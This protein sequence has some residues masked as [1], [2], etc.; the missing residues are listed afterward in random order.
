MGVGQG[1]LNITGGS[2]M[3]HLFTFLL[4]AVMV[5]AMVTGASAQIATHVVISEVY[6]GGG[7]SGA[8]YTHDFVELYNPTAS[9]VTMTNWSLQYQSATGSG[10][11]SLINVF[12]G[13]I[14]AH[15]FFLVQLAQGAG[16]S[17]SLPTPDATPASPLALAA[18]A[19]KVALVS[20]GT[21]IEF[22]TDPTVIDFVG[23]GSTANKFEG[24]GP[25]PTTTNATSVERKAKPNST[26]DSLVFSGAD[27][28]R[29]NGQDANQNG[30]DFVLRPYPGPQNSSSVTEVPPVLGNI[31]PSIVS[32]TRSFFVAEVSGVDTIKANV[33]DSDGTITGVKLHIRVNG[34]AV[35]SSI[36]MTLGTPPQY[37]GII[38]SSKHTTA[39]DLVEYWISATDNSSGYSTTISAPGGYFVGDAPI[40]SIKSNP[41]VSI[42]NYGARLNGTLNVKTH[43]YAANQGF[44]QD[45]TGGMQM[46]STSGMLNLDAN[47]NVKV[48]GTIINFGGAYELSSPNFAFVDTT[49][50]TT[51]LTPV[52][53]TLPTTQ[54]P[55]YVNEGKLVKIVN[56]TTGSAG[57]FA[58]PVNY[59]Y[60]E[61]D[62]DTITVRVESN[63]G[64]NT[65][66]GLPILA[67]PIDAIG[68]LSWNNGFQRL[69][70]RSAADMGYAAGDGSG[71]ATIAPT[72][73]FAGVS[74]VAETLTVTGDG[75]NTLEGVSVTIPSTWTWDGTSRDLAGAGFGAASS[76]VTGT[77][78]S[79]DPWVI[80]V[81]GAAVTN[82]NTGII[83][84]NNLT[85]PGTNGLTTWTTK[86]RI[87]SGTLNNVAVQPTVNIVSSHEAVASGNWS[88]PATWSSNAVP[89]ATDNVTMSTLNVTVTIDIDGAVC[90]NLTMT[91]SGSASNSGP[92]LQFD[93]TGIKS[94]TVNGSLTVGGGSGGGSGDRGGR[95]KLW[96]NGNN[97]ILLTVKGNITNTS[98][99]TPANGSAGISMNLGV[100]RMTG[101]T[102]DTLRFG[103]GIRLGSLEIG[104]GTNAKT[105]YTAISATNARL[106]IFSLVVKQN[107]AFWIGTSSNTNVLTIGNASDTG[108]VPILNGGIL[109][110][111][112]ASLRVQ[113]SSAGFVQGII[114][115]NG[116]SITNNG[117][118]DLVSPAARFADLTG[119]VYNVNVG[120]FSRATGGGTI[121]VGGPN[122]GDWANVTIDSAKTLALNQDMN[123]ASFAKV[124]I[125]NGT[126][127]E[128]AGNTV[129]GTVEATRTV[130]TLSVEGFGGIGLEVNA[131]GNAP[132]S[133]VVTRKTG[134]PV[135][136]GGSQSISRYFDIT[137]TTNTGLNATL[138]VYYDESEL[139]GNVEATLQLYKSTNAGA[140]W[141]A[142]GGTATP[143]LNRIQLL[144][145]ESLSRWTAADDNNPLGQ[146]TVLTT[147]IAGWNIIANPVSSPIPG[148][149]V[150][151]LFGQAL[152][153][154]AFKFV[155]GSGYQQEYIMANGLG[156]W[157]KFPASPSQVG[158]QGTPLNSLGVPVV[159]G[160]NLIGSISVVVDTAYVNANSGGIVT[161]AYY[162]F[163]GSYGSGDAQLIPGK[164]YWVKT[165]AAGTLNLGTPGPAEAP[166]KAAGSAVNPL[167]E[168]SEITITDSRGIS[169]TLYLGEDKT[170]EFPVS[171]YEMPPQGPEG[172]FD[173]RF[174]SQRM[175]EVYAERNTVSYPVRIASAQYPITVSWTLRGAADRV[176]T[177]S[178]GASVTKMHATGHAT[179]KHAAGQLVIGSG[180]TEI[181]TEFSLSQNYPNPFNPAT[182][183]RFGLPQEARVTL[184]V[185]NLLGQQMAELSNGVME[186]GYHD[187][188]WNGRTSVGAS[189]GSG[190]YFYKIEATATVTGKNYSE[191][192]KMVLLK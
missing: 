116:G 36:S 137:P 77:G 51:V 121:T 158:I 133:T 132:G 149:S 79:G 33:T 146:F 114:N 58:S 151:Q 15:G 165:N 115:I 138:N 52:T 42:V 3:K 82:V 25:A 160:W 47:R 175:V 120:G 192:R 163:N 100:V 98:S 35:D 170:G 156:Y 6:G 62:L 68:V 144:G 153:P 31:P 99:N 40:S 101:A 147:P 73:R 117:T 171:R 69:K 85:A 136:S 16:G 90:N 148:D 53:I 10:P 122:A 172:A 102:T 78:T 176:F 189:A 180:V 123:V 188:V 139:N 125:K 184:R 21:A 61:A 26:A 119:C 161:S 84:I 46:F 141:A 88:N 111:N 168:F 164:G 107:S 187:F 63:G 143:A 34:G 55:D 178:D 110:E 30:S 87:S 67:T 150:R 91:G 59:T 20:D 152:F 28:L 65:L 13:T 41:L 17:T 80:T 127:S 174:D 76:A 19:G 145:V 108:S 32:I 2:P 5:T 60:S 169:Q 39:G 183:I 134:S 27:S 23:Y 71:T 38:P 154:Y 97:T 142:Q 95:P 181:P 57:N 12:S 177:L 37:F 118:I 1:G 130:G 129:I 86:T 48:Q 75:T 126:L 157:E 167:E 45:A 182:T 72:F 50:G 105:V 185:F 155:P 22:P 135:V 186:S 4:F 112:G 54:S 159:A 190:V 11:F 166:A 7:N 14:P 106:A 131:A 43:L 104:D 74:A 9:P 83:R 44:I 70:P 81:T 24:G 173:V 140:S 49:L 179:L 128:T 92:V 64:A 89:T 94:L 29:G 162:G 96:D 103:A 8:V 191:V 18:A 93:G 56:V 109:I 124:T 66:V 113:E